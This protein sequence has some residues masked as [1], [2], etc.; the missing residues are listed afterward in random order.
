MT[1]PRQSTALSDQTSVE[2]S[3]ALQEGQ[4]TET[5]FEITPE[6]YGDCPVCGKKWQNPAVLPSGWVVCWKCG[7][8][9]VEGEDGDGRCP[10]TG[11]AVASGELRRV[12]V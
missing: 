10:I 11:M 7:F 6:T 4:P 1:P 2:L 9:A 12:L 5:A 3:T 8:D